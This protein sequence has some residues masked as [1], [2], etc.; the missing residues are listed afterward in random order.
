MH[1]A[2]VTSPAH[3]SGQLIERV[4]SARLPESPQGHISP[5]AVLRRH[6]HRTSLNG[7]TKTYILKV[8]RFK[9]PPQDVTLCA[10]QGRRMFSRLYDQCRPI[11]SVRHARFAH[12]LCQY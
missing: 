7:V 5:S 9:N 1:D 8:R 4:T 11:G 3:L 10:G 2:R 12:R 6:A